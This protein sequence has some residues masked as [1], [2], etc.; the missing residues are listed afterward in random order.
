MATKRAPMG[1]VCL[2]AMTVAACTTPPADY[3]ATLSQRDPKW[4]SPQCEEARRAALVYQA[5]EKETLSV[6]A[7][8]LLGPYGLGIALA[9]KEHREKQRRQFVRDMHLRC[10]SQPLPG[11]LQ[12][13]P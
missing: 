13:G 1:A 8:L 11:T 7:G 6:G 10:S 2:L 3:A 4:H 9:G 12:A 5:G